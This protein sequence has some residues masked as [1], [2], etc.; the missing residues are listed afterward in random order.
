MT[1]SYFP[2]KYSTVF[3]LATNAIAAVVVAFVVGVFVFVAVVDVVVAFV[4]FCAVVVFVGDVVVV[5]DDF[6]T[7]WEATGLSLLFP[8]FFKNCCYF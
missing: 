3:T 7:V 8:R 1:R 5:V 4:V 2:F 6:F